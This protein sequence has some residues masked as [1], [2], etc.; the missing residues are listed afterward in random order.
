M[1]K[2]VLKI[3]QSMNQYLQVCNPYLSTVALVIKKMSQVGESCTNAYD[4]VESLPDV[5]QVEAKT[6][7]DVCDVFSYY[8]GEVVIEDETNNTHENNSENNTEI[9]TEK[10]VVEE[11]DARISESSNRDE[12]SSGSGRNKKG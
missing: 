12:T 2:S 7:K 9:E 3:H 11:G 4:T 6:M 1:P 5:V 10:V 8:G